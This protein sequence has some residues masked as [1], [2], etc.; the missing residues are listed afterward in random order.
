MA[1]SNGKKAMLVLL[2]V[3]GAFTVYLNYEQFQYSSDVQ[4]SSNQATNQS[5]HQ[6]DKGIH[7]PAALGKDTQK[8][9]ER[10]GETIVQITKAPPPEWRAPVYSDLQNAAIILAQAVNGEEA[11][12]WLYEINSSRLAK[13]RVANSELKKQLSENL[14]ETER[15]QKERNKVNL[16]TDEPKMKSTAYLDDEEFPTSLSSFRGQSSNGST[17]GE[18]TKSRARL[19]L[20]GIRKNH[21]TLAFGDDYFPDAKVGQTA[22]NRYKVASINVKERFATVVDKR[23]GKTKTLFYGQ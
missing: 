15:N 18:V 9:I 5:S 3:A 10:D 4:V 8:I 17:G 19:V 1:L 14:L 22:F 13:V 20:K 21:V 23:S 6:A 7:S 2:G 12:A 16:N 11:A